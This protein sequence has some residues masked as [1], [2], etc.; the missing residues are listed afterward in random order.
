VGKLSNGGASV[1]VIETGG[2]LQV[3]GELT[4]ATARRALAAGL[5]ALEQVAASDTIVVDCSG[6]G[7]S[8]SAGL[9]VLIEWLKKASAQGRSLRFVG[10]P[11][12]IIAAARISEADAVLGI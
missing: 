4:F 10:L 6:V 7:E 9:A 12:G 11:A 8:D 3:K 2:Q 5:K 1:E